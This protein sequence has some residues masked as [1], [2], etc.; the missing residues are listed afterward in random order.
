MDG[1]SDGCM[2]IINEI[3]CVKLCNEAITR[4]YNILRL[5]H[6]EIYYINENKTDNYIELRNSSFEFL[7]QDFRDIRY[8]VEKIRYISKENVIYINTSIFPNNDTNI[9]SMLVHCYQTVYF[10]YICATLSKR[11]K[12]LAENSTDKSKYKIKESDTT[13]TSWKY[14]LDS[15]RN[16]YTPNYVPPVKIDMMAFAYLMVLKFHNTNISFK[17]INEKAFESITRRIARDFFNDYTKY[18]FQ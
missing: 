9:I 3:E 6:V 2:N 14:Y 11:K 17:N 12:M 18:R 7:S 4:A 10:Y 13:M 15:K 5:P 16:G 1:R 8:K